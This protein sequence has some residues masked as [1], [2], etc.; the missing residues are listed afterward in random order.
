MLIEPAAI[1]PVTDTVLPTTEPVALSV[2]VVTAA[3][4]IPAAVKAPAI[5]PVAPLRPPLVVSPVAV[6][7]PTVIVEA[8]T[9]LVVK[10]PAVEKA[11][12][13]IRLVSA[14]EFAVSPP[15][16]LNP[17]ADSRPETTLADTVIGP[18]DT[19][20]LAVTA[21]VLRPTETV[22]ELNE[23]DMAVSPPA[24][25]A[26]ATAAAPELEILPAVKPPLLD[27]DALFNAPV[28]TALLTVNEP[29]DC[30]PPTTAVVPTV[31]VPDELTEPDDMSPVTVPVVA[32]TEAADRAPAVE[33]YPAARTFAPAEMSPVAVIVAPLML[34]DVV[35]VLAVSAPV[36]TLPADS[37]L[38]MVAVLL[39]M[40][41]PV[42]SCVALITPVEATDAAV[43]APE[44]LSETTVAMLV[45][46]RLVPTVTAPDVLMSAALKEPV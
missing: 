34:A 19:K 20:L 30:R 2:V 21:A 41:P 31:R 3:V 27:T 33:K 4:E 40:A 12:A 11:P 46:T 10:V 16:V 17:P 45:T 39:D 26:L 23:P 5:A 25:L 44:A 7:K 1:N 38:V 28:T 8:I 9:L 37:K 43:T 32:T 13:D 18:L 36:L 14:A 22:S 35:I 29:A 24:M 42:A 6:S 15:V